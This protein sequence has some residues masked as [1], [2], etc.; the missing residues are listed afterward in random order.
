MF[1]NFVRTFYSKAFVGIH[2]DHETCQVNIIVIK[3]NKIKQNITTETKL[4]NNQISMETLKLIHFYRKKYPFT[5]IGMI[6][7]TQDQG[8]IPSA[9][10][11]EFLNYGVNIKQNH[12]LSLN[13]TWSTYIDKDKCDKLTHQIQ[14]LGALDCLFSPFI[15][16][17]MHAQK[18]Q[19]L[20]L[21][22]MQEKKTISVAICDSQ[23]TYYGK[24]FD[25]QDDAPM[26]DLHANQKLASS[27]DHLLSHL[28]QDIENLEPMEQNLKEE[29]GEDEDKTDELNDFVRATIIAGLLEKTINEYYKMS[30]SSFIDEMIFL[31]TYGISPSA[32]KYIQETLLLDTKIFPFSPANEITSLIFREYKRNAL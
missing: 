19:K 9:D 1:R 25:L 30:N 15:F 17:F 24:T 22:V 21:Y 8:A 16:I 7:K 20:A 5:Y 31:D 27:I 3:N 28:D 11:Q 26:L 14:E 32:L 10:T 2:L 13:N 23:C 4:I 18:Q 12:F 6:S 29:D